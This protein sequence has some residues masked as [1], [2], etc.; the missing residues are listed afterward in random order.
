MKVTKTSVFLCM[1][2]MLRRISIKKRFIQAYNV[3]LL[4]F[5]KVCDKVNNFFI[6]V[7]FKT[8]RRFQFFS[9]FSFK[10]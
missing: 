9:I 7:L 8:L 1:F 3:K 6:I 5:L 10:S 4:S 2:N